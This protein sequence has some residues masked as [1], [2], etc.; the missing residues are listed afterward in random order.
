[1]DDIQLISRLVTTSRTIIIAIDK[2]TS[3]ITT[4]IHNND[5]ELPF[6]Q[7]IEFVGE[8]YLLFL[9]VHC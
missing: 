8:I 9:T 5:E 6:Q 4:E 1:M 3:W 7:D 2:L